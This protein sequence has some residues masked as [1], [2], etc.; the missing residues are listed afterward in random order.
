MLQLTHFYKLW[1]TC[2]LMVSRFV[3]QK[4]NT[5]IYLRVHYMTNASA[6]SLVG[7]KPGLLSVLSER[8]L[9]DLRCRNGHYRLWSDKFVK[10]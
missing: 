1:M 3:L 4:L 10:L 5:I 7:C 8:K 9:V 2:N 6:N